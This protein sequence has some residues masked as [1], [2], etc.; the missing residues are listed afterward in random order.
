MRGD[1]VISARGLTKRYG[2]DSVV[3]R[4]DFEIHRGQC[5][6]FLGPNGAGKTTTLRMI[7]GHCPI[8]EGTLTV[9]GQSVASQAKSIRQRV[10]VVAQTD[11]LDPDFT[12]AENLAVYGTFFGIEPAQLEKRIPELLDFADLRA[13]ANV[14]PD[15]LSGG[16][17]RRL[18][19]VRALINDPELIVLDEPTTGLDPQ[20]R[21]LLWGRVREL[22]R[23]GKTILLTTHYLEEAE[24]L[25]DE[26]IIMDHGRILDRGSPRA[27]TRR[28]VEAEVLEITDCGGLDES[29][30]AQLSAQAGCRLERV[31]D[32]R[33]CYSNDAR[34]MIPQVESHR[35]LT[36]L[37]RPSNLEDVFLRLTGRELRN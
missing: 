34:S 9:F 25:C 15:A 17:K 7:L 14:K 36:Y 8:T 28:H 26:L 21:H 23:R 5:F 18:A 12:V 4:V 19:F 35:Q 13:K 3:D 16:M 32:T 22:T 27:L 24:R 6:G 33:Y 30:V 10:G 11:N 31:G 1:A 37:H 2:A 20:V 29:W